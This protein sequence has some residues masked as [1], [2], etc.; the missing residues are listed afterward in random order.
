MH[1]E[2][3]FPNY[4]CIYDMHA[5]MIYNLIL[6]YS[7]CFIVLYEKTQINY[8][9]HHNGNENMVSKELIRYLSVNITLTFCSY[10]VNCVNPSSCLI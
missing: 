8:T 1:T 4:M 10:I 3:V 2:F 7:E 5:H 9:V 6:I